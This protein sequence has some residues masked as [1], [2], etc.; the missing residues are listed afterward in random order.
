MLTRRQAMATGLSAASLVAAPAV[1]QGLTKVK[2]GVPNAAT[3]VGYFVAHARGYFRDEGLDVEIIPFDSAARMIAPLASGELQVAAGGPSA[4]LYNAVARGLDIRMVADKSKNIVGRSSIHILVRKSL[5][6]S[7]R[8]KTISDL[9]GL[10]YANGAPGSS[11]TT[12]FYM[13]CK[14]AGFGMDDVQE[15]SMGFPQQVAALESGA[16]DFAAPPDPAGTLAVRRGS[17]VLLIEGWDVIPVQQV[18]VTLYGG[19]FIKEQVDQGRRFMRAFLRGVRDHNDALDSNGRFVGPKGD[20][21]I[22][23]LV[24]Y[25]PFKDPEVYKSFV[26]AFCDPDGKL[27][28]PSLQI[29]IDAFRDLKLLQGPVDLTKVV[30]TS[31]LDWALRELGTYRKAPL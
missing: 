16:I 23:I 27:D 10:K 28:I 31:V 25:G 11:A 8:V 4:G 9:K 30:D 6:E 19:K 15:V 20:A 7:G 26:M 24:K 13:L 5:I 17:V 21:I 14:K 2:L 1:G 18:A 12:I 22:D 3:D 29:D